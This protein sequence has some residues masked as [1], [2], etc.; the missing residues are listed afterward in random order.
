[1]LRGLCRLLQSAGWETRAFD[2]PEAFLES[3]GPDMAGCLLLDVQMPGLNGLELQ[4]SLIAS[5][6]HLPIIFLTG[7]GD[8]PTSVRAMK[9][10]ALD[11]LMKPVQ[12]KEL[13]DAIGRALERDANERRE[14]RE[15]AE[16]E[17]RERLLTPREREVFSLVITGMLNKQIAG[18]L[19][20]TEK[21]IKV[22]RGRVMEKM[23]ARS[24]AELVRIAERIGLPSQPP[25]H[26][27]KVQ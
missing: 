11:F 12:E 13:F 27:T 9:A 16:I 18:R 21:T 23:R 20:T 19:G 2:T 26:E 15:R 5:D 3:A 6:C 22:H 17:D 4:H 14:R 25:P 7:H 8:V 1:M 24:I 10:G